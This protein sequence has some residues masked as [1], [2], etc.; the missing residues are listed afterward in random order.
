MKMALGSFRF[1]L[2]VLSFF[3]MAIMKESKPKN[4]Q[5]ATCVQSIYDLACRLSRL[6]LLQWEKPFYTGWKARRKR[7][8]EEEGSEGGRASDLS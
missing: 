4:E 1:V 3:S 7:E 8:A 2:L 6:P 5:N